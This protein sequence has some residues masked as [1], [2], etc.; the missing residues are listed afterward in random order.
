[1]EK[2]IIIF[3]IGL[4]LPLF[5]FSQEISYYVVTSG[6]LNSSLLKSTAGEVIAGRYDGGS[7]SLVSGFNYD[8]QTGQLT[9]IQNNE[10]NDI[11]INQNEIILGREYNQALI[12]DL[13]GHLLMNAEGVKSLDIKNLPAGIYLLRVIDNREQFTRKFVKF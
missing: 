6:G 7:G 4:L 2:K 11:V 13:N 8:F 1:M 10:I 9:D 12:I 5:T 3:I